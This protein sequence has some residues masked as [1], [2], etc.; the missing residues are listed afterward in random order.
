MALLPAP[1]RE[2]A[3]DIETKAAARHDVVLIE[4]QDPLTAQVRHRDAVLV[5]IKEK[6]GAFTGSDVWQIRHPEREPIER[7][8]FEI[9]PDGVAGRRSLQRFFDIEKNAGDDQAIAVGVFT[10]PGVNTP[11]GRH[12]N[13]LSACDPLVERGDPAT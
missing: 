1:T 7:A 8:S 6:H 5:L 12:Y 2:G 4:F 10:P 11:R 3:N 9:H 13:S